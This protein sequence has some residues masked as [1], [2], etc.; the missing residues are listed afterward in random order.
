MYCSFSA[1]GRGEAEQLTYDAAVEA[2][3]GKRNNLHGVTTGSEERVQGVDPRDLVAPFDAGDG[4]LGD[5]R[6]SG[7]PALG[8]PS[9]AAG[10][11]QG[12]GSVHP[13]MITQQLSRLGSR[14]GAPQLPVARTTHNDMAFL[15]LWLREAEDSARG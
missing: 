10:E 1:F 14:Q 2:H 5:A 4:G 15:S 9:P 13:S 6:G 8:E 7:Q 12:S 11:D 3:A